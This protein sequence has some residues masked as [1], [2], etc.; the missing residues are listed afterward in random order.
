LEE[1]KMEAYEA[2]VNITYKGNNGNLPD[3]VNYEA[4]NGDIL[5][6]AAEALR[7]GGVPGIPADPTAVLTDFVVDRFNADLTLPETDPAHWN[8]LMLRPKAPFG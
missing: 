5:G 1:M 4:T 8:R 7:T 3:P 2:T 6:W